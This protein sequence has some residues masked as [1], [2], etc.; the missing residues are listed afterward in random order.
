MMKDKKEK[1][2]ANSKEMNES[3]INRF[4]RNW[5]NHDVKRHYIENSF[6][7]T[8]K[9]LGVYDNDDIVK[10]ACDIII[11][12]LENIQNMCDKQEIEIKENPIIMDNSWD[13]ILQNYSYTIGKIL[14]WLLHY[15]FYMEL[16]EMKYVGFL[17]EHPHNKHSII[18]VSYNNKKNSNKN[19]VYLCLKEACRVNILL[20]KN[21]KKEFQ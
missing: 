18:R 6:D 9:T 20:F 12:H 3:E 4:L 2:L 15:K 21:I 19:Y 17:K 8:L 14:E 11:S 1:E 7:F 16:N 13:I 10:K 5:D